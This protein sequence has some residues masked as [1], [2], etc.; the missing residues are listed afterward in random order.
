MRRQYSNEVAFT[1]QQASTG[2]TKLKRGV[3]PN[4]DQGSE[5]GKVT[6]SDAAANDVAG[7]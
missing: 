5:L 3:F 4:P 1:L 6:F 2:V 7:G